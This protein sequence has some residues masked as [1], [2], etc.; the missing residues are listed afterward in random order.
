MTPIDI[1]VGGALG[2]TMLGIVGI[3]IV[4]MNNL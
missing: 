3:I 1:I 4:A 2:I